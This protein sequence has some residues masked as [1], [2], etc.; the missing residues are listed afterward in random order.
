MIK[1]IVQ[2]NMKAE[3]WKNE[4]NQ[5]FVIWSRSNNKM[6]VITAKSSTR[7][8]IWQIFARISQPDHLYSS[9]WSFIWITIRW[10]FRK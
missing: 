9:N 4:N 7:S 5:H 10:Q 6:N 1:H 8:Q 3:Y 2:M